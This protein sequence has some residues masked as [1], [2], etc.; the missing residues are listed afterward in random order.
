[1]TRGAAVEN[2]KRAIKFLDDRNLLDRLDESY[3]IWRGV[4]VVLDVM[5]RESES[6]E[7]VLH[8]YENL[9]ATVEDYFAPGPV[10]PLIAEALVQADT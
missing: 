7:A 5:L 4:P 8:A 3:V 6:R 10:P 9:A 2:A 1:M